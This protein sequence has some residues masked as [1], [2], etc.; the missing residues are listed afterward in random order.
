MAFQTFTGPEYLKIDIASNFGYDKQTWDERI[1]WF[2][3]NK[4]QLHALVSQAEEPALFY[5]G[6][7]AW[8]AYNAGKPSGYPISLDATCSGVQ[9]LA[10]LACDRSA[11]AITN[12]IDTGKREDAYTSIYLD[13]VQKIGGS[14]KIS[15]KQTKQA[16]MTSFYGSTAQPKN[17]FGEGELLRIFYETIQEQAPGPWS[18]NEHMLAIWDPTTLSNEW[19]LPD[20]FHVK[21]K[22][23][24]Q[25]KENVHFLDEP[26]E[27]AYRVNMPIKGGRSL[28]ANMVHSIDGMVVREMQRRCN[29]DP[30]QVKEILRLLDA[31]AS[32]RNSHRPKDK[33]VL[34]ILDHFQRTGF[35]SARVLGLIDVENSGLIPHVHLY[36][37][38]SSLPVKPF[39][40]VSV[41]DCF[42]CL[43]SY[44]NDL[45]RQYNQI[46]S[47]IAR[48]DMLSDI[49]GQIC[50]RPVQAGKMDPSMAQDIL[51]ANYALS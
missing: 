10:A 9:L 46:L 16:V 1:A 31:G 5:A 49:V 50:K 43:P 2:D 19:V 17:V 34:S 41:H 24:G 3:T 44:G 27:V 6:I 26:F 11:G 21:I 20:N 8:E 47:E 48:S 51:E 15:R 36:N 22:V 32:G 39:E 13:M 7:L 25:V 28:G 40:V 35:L 42:R 33:L 12:L 23:M 14:A 29:F 30:R 18:I 4:H 45:R 38:I 37:L